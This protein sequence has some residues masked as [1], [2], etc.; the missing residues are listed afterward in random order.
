[1]LMRRRDFQ[2]LWGGQFVSDLGG[3]LTL[4]AL[5]CMLAFAVHA[6]PWQMGALQAAETCIVPLFA[7]IVGVY[8]D[9][10]A[11]RPLMLAANLVRFLAILALALAACCHHAT[12]ACSLAT[13]LVVASASL[14]FDTAYQA[15]L[16]TLLGSRDIVE[17]NEE[18][19][20]GSSAAQVLGTSVAG[21][22]VQGIGASLAFLLN[23]G[24]FVVATVA[25]LNIRCDESAFARERTAH[26]ARRRDRGGRARNAVASALRSAFGSAERH[27]HAVVPYLLRPD[28]LRQRADDPHRARPERSTRA[29]ERRDAHDRLGRVAARQR[30]RRHLRDHDRF[31]RD[32]DRGRRRHLDGAAL[33]RG[34]PA[35][36]V[37]PR[38]PSLA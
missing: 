27:P 5:P 28:L 3:H 4:V 23:A 1:M 20:A 31:Q 12:F 26:R 14:L 9:R 30:D 15:F 22:L 21:A 24:T 16:P 11:R 8:V 7:M 2:L 33:L 36:P 6:A 34:L 25:L 38:Q 29:D 37:A 19:A 13:A 10:L 35:D 32:D 18:L 17:G